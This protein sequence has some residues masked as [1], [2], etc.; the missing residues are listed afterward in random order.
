MLFRSVISWNHLSYSWPIK[1]NEMKEAPPYWTMNSISQGRSPSSKT[2]DNVF[3][4]LDRTLR[5]LKQKH[6]RWSLTVRSNHKQ[7]KFS[8]GG[9]E[10]ILG[11][12]RGLLRRPSRA[13]RATHGDVNTP[14][15]VTKDERGWCQ[16]FGRLGRTVWP[17]APV[18]GQMSTDRQTERKTER[19]TERQT[20]PRQIVSRTSKARLLCKPNEVLG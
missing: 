3:F 8:I 16:N 5:S 17:A 9:N 11:P 20:H 6:R 19:K 10:R 14:M 1:I 2:F 4:Q 7:C 18:K 15:H 12:D 13:N